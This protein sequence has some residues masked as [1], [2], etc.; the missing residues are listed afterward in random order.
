MPS[1]VAVT[2]APM[3]QRHELQLKV[4]S[5][6]EDQRVITGLATTPRPDRVGDIV[7]PMGAEFQPEIPL[8][9]GHDH[10]QPVGVARLGRPTPAGI[11]FE[12][13]I[14]K[15]AEPG[16]LKGRVDEAW[17]AVKSGILTCVS[18]GFRSLP[19]GSERMPNGGIRYSRIEIVE[20]SLVTVPAQ[21][22]ARILSAKAATGLSYA[23]RP[24]RASVLLS[25]R[26]EL[27]ITPPESSTAAPTVKL[28]LIQAQ[29]LAA[30][31]LA[32]CS[33]KGLK[34]AVSIAAELSSQRSGSGHLSS[35]LPVVHLKKQGVIYATDSA[36][37]KGVVYLSTDQRSKK[38][39]SP[40]PKKP[41]VTYLD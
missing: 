14:A 26:L 37:P 24:S 8:L 32:A 4:R 3:N 21:A 23:D 28:T 17:E 15:I 20:L 29:D 19:G 31:L 34:S 1:V 7:D 27:S 30:A 35:H 9:M 12:A 41:G 25:P 18:I 39:T 5:V 33:A 40:R 16:T 13:R 36:R 38:V 2:I 6:A 11:P 22:D 10:A